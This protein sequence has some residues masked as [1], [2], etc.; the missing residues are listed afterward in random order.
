M[1]P[2]IITLAATALMFGCHGNKQKTT[3]ERAVETVDTLTGII[4]LRELHIIDRIQV[5]SKTYTYQ[6]DF[7]PTDDV[8]RNPQG[9]DYHDNEVSLT[10]RQGTHNILQR[11][12]TKQ[13]FHNLVPA[14][15]MNTSVLCGFTYDYTKADDHTA[16]YFIAT[17]GD[18]DETADM[19]FPI[20]LKIS[21]SGSVFMEKATN[22]DTEPIHP[23]M[24]IDPSDEGGV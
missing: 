10:I 15:F 22:L 6:F 11:T 24:T 12:F 20:S 4:T 13:D 23:G 14:E 18:G 3:P 1:K 16:L 8:V 19:S 9:D 21:T 7:T 2:F 5:A 17:V